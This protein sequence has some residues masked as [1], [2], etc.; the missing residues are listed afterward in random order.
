MMFET[1]KAFGIILLII[2]LV[3]TQFF[4]VGI[5]LRRTPM[6]EMLRE[7]IY[8]NRKEIQSLHNSLS[9]HLEKN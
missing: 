2:T 6:F 1:L 3:L 9:S 8:E 7:E 5:L 4:Q